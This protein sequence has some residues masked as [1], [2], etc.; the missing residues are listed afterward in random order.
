MLVLHILCAI[1]GFGAVF[2]N[3]DLRPADARSGCSRAREALGIFEAN[4]LVSKIGEYFIYAVFVFGFVARA[5][6]ATGRGSSRQT[7]VWLSM[8][9]YVV[10]LGLSHG[11][12]FPR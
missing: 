8:V 9:L 4:Y 2:L 11:V 10:A 1:V 6:R 5:A 12:L 7:W 3:G